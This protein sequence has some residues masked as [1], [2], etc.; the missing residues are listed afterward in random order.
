M[1]IIP[2]EQKIVLCYGEITLFA[3]NV[4]EFSEFLSCLTFLVRQ[5]C[6]KW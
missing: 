5:R 2:H 4:L 3:H 1:S 6:N